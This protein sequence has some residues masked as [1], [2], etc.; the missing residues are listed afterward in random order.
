MT[1][2]TG[3]PGKAGRRGP[4]ATTMLAGNLLLALAWV[5]MT[6]QFRVDTPSTA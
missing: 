1:K 3:R 2:T 5:A 4:P 6:G